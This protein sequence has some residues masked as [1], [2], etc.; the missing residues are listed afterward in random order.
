M[1]NEL[2]S[3]ISGENIERGGLTILYLILSLLALFIARYF[4]NKADINKKAN[5]DSDT[6]ILLSY[7]ESIV[8][9][10]VR[11]TNQTFVDDL[12]EQEDFTEE[13]HETAFD[14]TMEQIKNVLAPELVSKLEGTIGDFNEYLEM[15][16]EN[17]VSANKSFTLCQL[18]D[19]DED[20]E[21]EDCYEDDSLNDDDVEYEFEFDVPEGSNDEVNLSD[22]KIDTEAL[23]IEEEKED[24]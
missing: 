1:N 16:I 14:M 11:A 2:F 4:K 17:K 7:V 12:K 3:F 13:D 20:D 24:K 5:K 6:S 10:A 15:L 18:E 21:D 23:P 8:D 9:M 19:T 22:I